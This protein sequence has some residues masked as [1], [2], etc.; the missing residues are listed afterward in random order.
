MVLSEDS[1]VLIIGCGCFGVSTAYH[2]LIR[3]FKHVTIIDRSTTLPAPDAA[4]YD[5]NKSAPLLFTPVT[6][7]S[8]LFTV[9]RS[10]YND[11]FYAKLA[12]EAIESWKDE[13]MWGDAYHQYVAVPMLFGPE[14]CLLSFIM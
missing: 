10:S 4:S 1:K 12:R 2:L 3:G 5:L 14:K 9:V 8:P 13:K 6:T 7:T 11:I